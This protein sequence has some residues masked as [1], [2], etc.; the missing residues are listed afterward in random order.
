[1]ASKLFILLCGGSKEVWYVPWSV[2]G[3]LNIGWSNGPHQ[4]R[5]LKMSHSNQNITTEDQREK[6]MA[7]SL[8]ERHTTHVDG[9]S[10]MVI[11]SYLY[12]IVGVDQRLRI[13]KE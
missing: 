2:L 6:K 12:T 4:V 1:M 9:N 8:K 5:L 3:I 13:R 10:S 11:C 7:Q